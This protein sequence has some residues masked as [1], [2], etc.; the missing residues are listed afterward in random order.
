MQINI[1]DIARLIDGQI[2]G[3]DSIIISGSCKIEE[4]EN[5]KITFLANQKYKDF[6]YTTKASV[7]IVPKDFDTSNDHLPTLIKVDNVYL[8]LSKLLEKFNSSISINDG[9]ATTAIIG[10]D[11]K[12]GENVQID[13]FVIIKKGVK[14]GDN[15]KIYGQVFVGDN[16]TIGKD[17]ILYPGVKIYHGCIIGDRSTIHANTVIGSDGFGFAK[18]NEGKYT[19]IPQSGNVVIESDV[20]IGSNTV[21]DRA[22]FGSTTIKSG[23]KLD[24]LIQIAHNVSVGSNTAVAAQVGIAGS[25]KI[26]SNCLIGGQVGIVGHIEIADG[27]MI[28]AQSGVASSIKEPNSKWYGYPAIDYQA[29]LKSFA[30]F[31]KLP[32]LFQQINTLNK[33]NKDN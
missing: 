1:K 6:I 25:T 27:A 5:G 10:D 3:D 12:L 2:E 21:I 22:S 24:N 19:K 14:I 7:V 16:V 30:V 23:T 18:D 8:A 33:K 28:Q 15:T 9:I 13:D 17:C 32:E 11:A 29:Y 26:G 4:G 31:K 20:E